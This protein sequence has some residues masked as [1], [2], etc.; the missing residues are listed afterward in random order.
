MEGEAK[1]I[2]EFIMEHM[3]FVL[4]SAVCVIRLFTRRCAY[5]SNAERR[6]LVYLFAQPQPLLALCGPL[7]AHFVAPPH[8]P[9]Q[10]QADAEPDMGSASHVPGT[11]RLRQATLGRCAGTEAQHEL[12]AA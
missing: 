4:L 3:L 12:V 11:C 5:L 10:G 7:R 1:A 6:H 2:A 9:K 8:L